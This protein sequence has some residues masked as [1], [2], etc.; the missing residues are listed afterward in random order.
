MY[1]TGQSRVDEIRVGQTLSDL[2]IPEPTS[3]AVL[4]VGLVGLTA[5]RRGSC[6]A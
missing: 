5:R 2:I 1:M 4:T 6:Q 3:L